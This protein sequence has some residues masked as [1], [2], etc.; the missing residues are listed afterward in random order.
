MRWGVL[1]L[2][3]LTA[4]NRSEGPDTG[5]T[6]DTGWFSDTASPENCPGVVMDVRPDGGPGLWYW[7][8]MPQVWTGND[9]KETYQASL[10]KG[11]N[12][13]AS[14]MVWAESGVTFQV[15]R[16]E[17]FEP[18]TEYELQLTDCRETRRIGFKTSEYGTPLEGDAKDLVSST[19]LIDLAGATWLE[20]GSFSA[21]LSLYFTTP[22]LL[23]VN[24]A[25]DAAVDFM[26]AQGYRDDLGIYR[27]S[28]TEPTFDFPLS[29]WPEKPYFELV[30]PM[31]DITFQGVQVPIYDFAL[32]GTFAPDGSSL[33]GAKVQGL[34]D[35]RYMG[36]L[37]GKDDPGAICEQAASLG[38]SCSD[39]PDGNPYCM[40]LS[41]I[42]VDGARVPGLELTPKD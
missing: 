3:S 23:M 26:G 34:G 30:A 15:S 16:S 13:L 11:T 18:N 8:D 17:H 14:E 12:A 9:R 2:L 38:V 1:L 6:V 41:A 22:I 40:F 5:P 25:D 28:A 10:W 36:P 39:C 32:S 19:Y 35:T 7:R 31:V 33:G 21:I 20:P 4:C 27:Q 29:Q 24:Y 42:D 37:I